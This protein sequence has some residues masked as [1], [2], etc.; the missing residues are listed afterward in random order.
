MQADLERLGWTEEQWN[1]IVGTVTEEAQKARVAAQALPVS[2]P[3]DPTVVAIPRFTLRNEPNTAP[4]PSRRLT[5]NSDPSLY[6][7]T[8]AVN[9]PLRAREMADPNLIAALGMFRRAANHIARIE[10][11]LVFY[12]R[13]QRDSPPPLGLGTMPEVFQVTGNGQ[14]DGLFPL[15]GGLRWPWQKLKNPRNGA[16]IVNDI[17]KVIGKLEASGQLGPFACVLDQ[18]LFSRICDP[19]PNSMVL[20]RDRLLP[21]LQGPLLRSSVI[22]KNYGVVVALS[23]TPVEIVVASDI[24]VTYLQATLEPR[25]VFRISERVALR[26]RERRAIVRLQP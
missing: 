10:D 22:S 26:V 12:G 14:V 24:D 20:P 3:E 11:A 1:R 7:T 13:L 25:Y 9:V 23:G 8:I 5:V 18:Q 15:R 6:L 4:P 17:I 16:A 19:N 2:G 21:F